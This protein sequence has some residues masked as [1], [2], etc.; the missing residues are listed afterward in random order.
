MVYSTLSTC[1]DTSASVDKS[2]PLELG[3]QRTA[4]PSTAAKRPAQS[5]AEISAKKQK[6]E[7]TH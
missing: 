4:T 5:E 6:L 3:V 1:T 7:V 2:A